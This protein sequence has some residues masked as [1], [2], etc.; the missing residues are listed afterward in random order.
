MYGTVKE[1][2]QYLSEINPEQPIGAI[3]WDS[4]DVKDALTMQRDEKISDELAVEALSLA[5]RKHDADN[6]ICWDTFV[7]AVDVIRHE[8]ANL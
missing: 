1:V 5:I 6:G 3:F 2:I 8:E 7:N 4:D